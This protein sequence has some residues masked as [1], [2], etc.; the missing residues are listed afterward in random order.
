MKLAKDHLDIGLFTANIE[1]HKQFWGETVG[2]RFD[3]ELTLND[4]WA[5]HRYDAH[6]SVI[7]VNEYREPLNNYAPSGYTTLTIA[8][9][10][11]ATWEGVH[12]GGE[13]V[14]LVAPGTDGVHGIAITVSTPDRERMMDFYINAMEFEQ[15]DTYIA[16]CG[17]SLLFV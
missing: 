8:A 12:P 11:N 3:H 15:E 1:A 14:R 7:K 17:D 16:K 9:D 10:V 6:G 4:Q 13:K 2:L 5:Q